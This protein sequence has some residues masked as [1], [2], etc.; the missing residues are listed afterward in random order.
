MGDPMPELIFA[1]T[2]CP[3]CGAMDEAQASI[4]CKQTQGWD[5]EY[6]C[7][8]EFDEDGKSV[9]PTPESSAALD[10]WY[11][12]QGRADAANERT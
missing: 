9:Q 6:W 12:R 7:E 1:P 3:Q 4:L 10:A 5:G 2:P 8:G 11:D